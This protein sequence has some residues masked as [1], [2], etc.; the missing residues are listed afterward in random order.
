MTSSGLP[1]Q[2]ARQQFLDGSK[3]K[4]ESWDEEDK[5]LPIRPAPHPAGP[6]RAVG[7]SPSAKAESLPLS[8]AP[9]PAG[10]G[11]AVRHSPSSQA[12]KGVSPSHSPSAGH[13]T[14]AGMHTEA[15]RRSPGVKAEQ[16]SSAAAAALQAAMA[17]ASSRKRKREESSPEEG[18]VIAAAEAALSAAQTAARQAMKDLKAWAASAA[19]AHAARATTASAD[20]IQ[21]N[22]QQPSQAA[23][24][25]SPVQ[26]PGTRGHS[27]GV[28]PT[29]ISP[30]S[31]MP[32][33]LS[34]SDDDKPS[35]NP[36]PSP[37]Q[38][39]PPN[40]VPTSSRSPLPTRNLRDPLGV[41]SLR[42]MNAA[43]GGSHGS[44]ESPIVIEISD[45]EDIIDIIDCQRTAA[46]V[47][48]AAES[49]GKTT[50]GRNQ[51]QTTKH[52]RAGDSK[53]AEDKGAEGKGAGPWTSK[54]APQSVPFHPDMKGSAAMAPG[55]L[56]IQPS[57][58]GKLPA[59]KQPLMQG[60][61]KRSPASSSLTSSQP[62]DASEVQECIRQAARSSALL[63]V[64]RPGRG[65]AISSP[66]S[67]T[68]TASAGELLCPV[69]GSVRS[70][71]VTRL[72]DCMQC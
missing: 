40:P 35:P 20:G 26:T 29:C 60:S 39:P 56:A 41:S 34:D 38:S 57:P 32:I 11:R 46:H 23:K 21:S 27:T 7:H 67:D 52:N 3:A 61:T 47:A 55:P 51:H 31:S 6:S 54:A 42:G 36:G 9:A 43:A 14:G 37:K 63:S 53:G 59:S 18:A 17:V 45:D 25:R 30:G 1:G 72:L 65:S 69:T 13:V 50:D 8:L 19:E 12:L 33:I 15:A 24:E 62:S 70:Q 5:P 28:A 16:A 48:A 58:A 49:G 22:L 4:H 44:A 66:A 68:I 2:H 71:A 10:P 64:S